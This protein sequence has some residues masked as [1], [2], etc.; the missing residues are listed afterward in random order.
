MR[1]FHT[2]L[3]LKNFQHTELLTLSFYYVTIDYFSLHNKTN[4]IIVYKNSTL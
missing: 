3:N 4:L 2:I 1:N